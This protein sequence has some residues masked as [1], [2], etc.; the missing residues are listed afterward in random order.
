MEINEL[1]QQ[2]AS[3]IHHWLC[4]I[5]LCTNSNL[6]AE[7]SVRY[8]FAEYLE[9]KCGAVVDLEKKHPVFPGR[10]IDFRFKVNKSLLFVELKYTS[11]A[12]RGRKEIQRVFNDL[13]RL[14]LAL[15]DKPH[16]KSYF[17]MCGD[18]VTFNT[19]FRRIIDGRTLKNRIRQDGDSSAV[20]DTPSGAYA[21]WFGFRKDD[22]VVIEFANN[23]TYVNAFLDEYYNT[24]KDVLKKVDHSILG[25]SSIKTIRAA[26]LPRGHQESRSQTVAI[27]E[28]LINNEQFSGDK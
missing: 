12:T 11:K 7:N 21:Q 8:P 1:I 26:Y 5:S 18:T 13:I 2:L 17:I 9:R 19:N 4:Y 28:V 20:N 14:S 24:D 25:F 22:E 10:H 6:L 16:A 15:R 27:W 3:A 23:R